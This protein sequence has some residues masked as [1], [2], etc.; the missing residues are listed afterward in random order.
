M[1]KPQ[2]NY[3]ILRMEWKR[4]HHQNFQNTAKEAPK[5]KL[6]AFSKYTYQKIRNR[7]KNEQNFQLNMRISFKINSKI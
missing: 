4:K 7:K 6:K 2:K 5:D 3:K 1:L